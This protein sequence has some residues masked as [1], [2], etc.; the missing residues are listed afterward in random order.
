MP[1]RPV[2]ALRPRPFERDCPETPGGL[3]ATIETDRL[4]VVIRLRGSLRYD[5]AATLRETVDAALTTEPTTIVLD[6]ADVVADDDLGLWVVP[7]VAGH[8]HRG[9]VD[10]VVVAPVRALRLRLRRLGGRPVEITDTPPETL[11]PPSSA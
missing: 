4:T 8:A 11:D 7:A 10:F 2:A 9:G 1:A 6:L 5:T 3:S